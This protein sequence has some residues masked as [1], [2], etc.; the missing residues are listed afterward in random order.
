M[1]KIQGVWARGLMIY[2]V[3]NSSVLNFYLKEQQIA[4]K[5]KGDKVIH[6]IRIS[7]IQKKN[8]T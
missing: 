6:G 2:Q 5:V 1:V 8:Y 3:I 7:E 4:N